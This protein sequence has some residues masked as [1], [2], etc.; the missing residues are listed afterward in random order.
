MA[1]YH[2]KEVLQKEISALKAAGKTI[3]LVPTMGALHQG[4]LSLVEEA[5]R[6]NDTVVVS[7]FVN[8]TQFDNKDDLKKYPRSLEAD[9]GILYAVNPDVL[10]FAPDVEEIYDSAVTSD[11]F[12]FD[13]LEFRM[14]GKFREGH[15][16]GV[17]TIVKRLFEIIRPDNAYFGEKDY[18]QLQIIKTLVGK[19]DIPVS[20][21]GC[22]VKREAN[23]LAMSSRNERL[24]AALRR[25]AGFI[26][27]TLQEA[28]ENFRTRTPESVKELVRERFGEHP[29]F[30]LEYVEIADA[31]TLETAAQKEKGKKYRAFVAVF[32]GEVRLIDNIALN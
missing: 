22:P 16:D 17:G 1:V 23:G 3:G 25:E 24:P 15:F 19:Y 18:Q 13:G 29:E 11:H 30:R 27:R 9:T 14:E 4:H 6:E 10:V 26:F 12:D 20:V 31:G 21:H 7:I 8:P 32:A 28:R 2:R 5:T